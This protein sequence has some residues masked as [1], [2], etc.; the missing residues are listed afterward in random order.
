MGSEMCIRDRYRTG[1]A[2]AISYN[3]NPVI[4]GSDQNVGAKTAPFSHQYTVTDG[5]AAS[6]TLT[7]TETVT[8][9][10]ETITL[11]TYTATSG[12]QNTA[13]LSGVWLRLLTGT[14][15]L[16]IYVT[17]GAGGSATRQ[18]TF[19]RTVN[20]IAAS[21]A[22]STDAKVTKVFL[23]LYPADHPADATLHVEV[24]NN[25]FDT[26]PVWEDVTSK[27]G[28]FVHTF[29]NTTV[30]KGFGLAYRFYLTKGTQQIEVI[31][32]TV[33]FA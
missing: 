16:K 9:G 11:R 6:Q 26:A 24:T 27:V 3:T 21:R 13:D 8:N 33:R 14:H 15:V 20:R 28:K 12:H 10:S 17:D 22:I 29:K 2:Q 5:E 23:S 7:V 31:Q 30:A 19:T 18:I 4:S 1:N 32:A 25:P